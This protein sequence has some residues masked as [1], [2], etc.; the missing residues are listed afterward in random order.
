[1]HT[2]TLTTLSGQLIRTAGF[3]SLSYWWWIVE[4]IMER[5]ECSEDDVTLL[6]TSDGDMICVGY[7][8]VAIIGE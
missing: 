4:A 6:E 7:R 8:P 5:F 1:M 2:I 3:T